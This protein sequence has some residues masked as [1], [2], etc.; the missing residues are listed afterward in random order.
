MFFSNIYGIIYYMKILGI[1]PGY[2]IMGYGIIEK[3]GSSIYPIAY[4]SLE[5][6]KSLSM[7]DRLK[8]L[9]AGLMEV[10]A[11]YQ[12]E[13]AS[14]EELYFQ[15]N[16]K[17]AIFVGEARGI[18]VLACVNSGVDIFEYTPMQIKT[19]VTGY[20]K[21]DKKQVQE[22]VKTLCGFDHIIQP[23]DTSDAIAAAICHSFQGDVKKSLY[24]MK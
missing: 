12:P 5:T 24:R 19:S 16:A 14:I 17:T 23:D 10:I 6:D 2:A 11:E 8:H 4:G 3:K 22:M 7:P 13:E 9:Y 20:G 21:A 18:A 1:D 15:N